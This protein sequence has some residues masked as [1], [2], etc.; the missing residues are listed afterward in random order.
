MKDIKVNGE[1]FESFPTYIDMSYIECLD[2]PNDCSFSL[3]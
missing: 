3:L 1:G 2:Y